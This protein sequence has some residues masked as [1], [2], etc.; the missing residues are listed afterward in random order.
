MGI[1]MPKVSKMSVSMKV[2]KISMPKINFVSKPSI[3]YAKPSMSQVT[4]TKI[5]YK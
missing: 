2:P 1:S 4:K 5:K 3:G